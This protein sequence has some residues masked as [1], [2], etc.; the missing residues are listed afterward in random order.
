MSFGDRF[1]NFPSATVKG[2]RPLLTG[3]AGWARFNSKPPDGTQWAR[4]HQDMPSILRVYA[5][6]DEDFPRIPETKVVR[7]FESLFRDAWVRN[8]MDLSAAPDGREETQV[9]LDYLLGGAQLGSFWRRTDMRTP[10]HMHG[11]TALMLKVAGCY[12][13]F[14]EL[15]HMRLPLRLRFDT[16]V[17]LFQ[18]F[19]QGLGLEEYRNVVHLDEGLVAE[20]APERRLEGLRKLIEDPWFQFMLVVPFLSQYGVIFPGAGFTNSIHRMERILYHP[21]SATIPEM[22]FIQGCA[23]YELAKTRMLK[24][25]RRS[26]NERPELPIQP[27]GH[28]YYPYHGYEARSTPLTEWAIWQ[29]GRTRPLRAAP[30]FNPRTC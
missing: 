3:E 7:A 30:D 24:C 18:A 29:R 10:S 14:W 1:S 26:A 2:D 9:L 20:F 19:T 22:E 13:A 11:S 23:V 17:I 12:I 21:Y 16:D 6:S 5:R 8:D 28:W 27:D 4:K 25:R 15:A